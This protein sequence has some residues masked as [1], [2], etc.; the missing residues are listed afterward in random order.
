MQL[1]KPDH[2]LKEHVAHAKWLLALLAVAT[3]APVLAEVLNTVKDLKPGTKIFAYVFSHEQ[4]E[5][6]YKVGVF[7]DKKLGLQQNC[8]SQFH[9]KP[10]EFVILAPI[11]LPE[12]ELHPVEGAWKHR[13]EFERCG[14]TKIYNAI[15]V[16]KKGTKAELRPYFPGTSKASP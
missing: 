9:I 4:M 11:N 2:F 16:S 15:F 14:D 5:E 1:G 12:N 8:K 7:W 10:V 13:F 6:L 3:C